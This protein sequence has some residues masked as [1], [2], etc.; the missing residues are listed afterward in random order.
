MPVSV[1]HPMLRWVAPLLAA[2]LACTA[3]VAIAAVRASARD[4]LPPRSAAQLLVDVQKARLQGLSGTVVQTSALGLPALPDVAGASSANLTSLLSGSHT[5][6]VWYAGPDRARLALL[7]GLGES[8][9]IRNGNDV[10]LWSSSSNSATH[11]SV[12]AHA[13]PASTG[14]PDAPIG[15]ETPRTPQQAADLALAAITPTTSVTTDPTAVVAG[16]PAYELVLT[17]K[18]SQTLVGTVRIAIDGR[19]HIPTRVQVYA[20]GSPG[21]PAFEIGFTSFDP[22][23]PSSSVF[24]FNPPPGA[25][26]KEGVARHQLGSGSSDTPG[27]FDH[28]TSTRPTVV[29]DG[30][31]TIAI[32]SVPA[33][34]AGGTLGDVVRHLPTVTGSWG[35]GHVLKGTLFTA[36]LTDDGRLAVGS[37]PEQALTTALAT[38]PAPAAS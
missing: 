6:R 10:W 24:A 18:D 25:T 21:Q 4:S 29:G 26:V 37:V 30:W 1:R 27:P 13:G 2:V 32:G 15:P 31:S 28:S 36:I 11:F 35:S 23:A 38:S 22:H 12:P 14:T 20:K 8:D 17:P 16:R 9:I 3:G 5:L 34:A 33:G 7:D 19:T